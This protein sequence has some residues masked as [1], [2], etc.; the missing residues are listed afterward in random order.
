MKHVTYTRDESGIIKR[1]H[2]RV[3]MTARARLDQYPHASVL[4]GWPERWIYWNRSHGPAVGL[5]PLRRGQA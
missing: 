1:T 5:A 2:A 4:S 3:D